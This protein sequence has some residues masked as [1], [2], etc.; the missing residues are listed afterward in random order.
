MLDLIK[1]ED[2]HRALEHI[3]LDL[4]ENL[5]PG[6]G[7]IYNYIVNNKE[8]I[9]Y[10]SYKEKGYYIGSGPIES[11][12][13]VVIQQRMKQSGMRWGVSGGQYISTLRAKYESNLWNDVI[14]VVNV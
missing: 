13:K 14:E 11:G 7:N 1:K 2:I 8:R 10:K 5:P 6:V 3:S 12:N 9:K 4:I